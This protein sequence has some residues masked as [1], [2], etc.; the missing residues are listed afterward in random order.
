LR[1]LGVE[2]DSVVALCL[3]RGTDMVVASLAVWQAGAAYLPLDPEYPAE[4]LRYMVTDSRARVLVGHRAVAGR[5]DAPAVVWLD[6]DETAAEAQPPVRVRQ[7]QL[8]YVVYTSGS[9]GRPKGVQVRHGGVLNLVIGQEPVFGTGHEPV[10]WFA[11]FGFDGAV[12]EM[13]VP[14]AAGR[15]VVV[16]TAPERAEPHRLARLVRARAIGP[17]TLPPSL[18]K[19]FQPG[20]LDG[21]GTLA[22]GGERLEPGLAAAWRARHRMVNLY[23]P[24]ETTVCATVAEVDPQADG[25]PPIGAPVT[26]ARAYVVDQRLEPAPVGVPGELLVGGAGVARGYAGRPALTAERFVADPFAGDGSRAYRTGDRARWLPDGQLEFLGRADDQVKVRGFRIEPG[27]VEAVLA[28]HPAVRD[29]VVTAFGPD[30]DR[31]LAA[32]LVPAGPGEGLPPVADLRAFAGDRLPAFMVPAVFVELAALPVTATGKL[33]RAALPEPEPGRTGLDRW[34]EPAGPAEELIAGIWSQVLGVDRVGALDDFLELGG[35]SLLATQV[36][37]RM[38]A[39]F[40]VEIPLAAVFDRPTVRALAAL[41]GEEGD[42]GAPPIVP[43]HRNG[44]LPL[45]FAQQRLWFLDQLDPA[46]LEYVVPVRLRFGGELDFAALGGAL[47]VL[48]ARHEVLRTRLVATDGEAGQVIDLPAPVPLPVVDVSDAIDPWAVAQAVLTAGR[49]APFDL[50]AGP[51]LRACLIR[52]RTGDHI[53][54]LTLHHIVFDEWSARILRRELTALYE[55]LRA[56]EPDPLPPLPVQYRDFAIWQ[57]SWLSGPV[58]ERQLAYWREQ[59]SGPPAPEL[60]TDRPRPAMRSTRGAVAGFTVPAT[61]AD[62]LRVLSRRSGSTM[63]MTLYAALAV[64][65]GRYTGE[66]SVRIGTPVANRNRAE[67][68]G[69]IGFFVNT[70]VL[71]ADLSGDPAFTEVLR[72]VRRTALAAYAHQDLPFEQLVDEL[73]TE[74]DRSRTPLFQ[75][76]FNYAAARPDA[77]A[78]SD[79]LA[80]PAAAEITVKFDLAVVVSDG[81]DGLTGRLEYSTALFDSATAE[82]M[83]EHLTTLLTAVA[84]DAGRHLSELPMLTAAERDRVARQWQGEAAPAPAARSVAELIGNAAQAAPDAPAVVS[85]SAALTY[86]GLMRRANRLAHRLRR[87]GVGPESVVAMCLDRGLD[88]VVAMLAV[89]Q[90]GGAFLPLD[91]EYPAERLTYLLADSGTTVLVGHRSVAGDLTGGSTIWLDDPVTRAA[92]GTEPVTAPGGTAAAGQLAYVIYTSGSTGRPKGVQVAQ[93][94]AVNMAVALRATLGAAPGR[95]VLQFASF[96]FDASVL[97]VA[98]TLAAGG[99]LVV[100]G[101]AQRADPAALTSLVRRTG[102]QATSVTPSLLSA[103]DP[104]RLAGLSTLVL[105]GEP[106]TAP[107]AAA[108]RPGRRLVNTYGP[109]ETT[110]MVTTGAV[111]ADGHRAPPIGRPVPGARTYVLDAALRP[112]PVGVIG[113]LFIGGRPVARGY[114]HRPALT[115]ERFLADPFAADGSRMYRTGDRVR[116]LPDG[117]LDFAGRADQQIKLRGFRIEPAEVEAVLTGHAAVREAVVTPFGDAEDRRLVAYLVP[118]R[119]ADGIPSA[120]ELREHLRRSLPEFMVPAVF[121]E[122][123]AIPLT[124]NGKTDLTALPTPDAAR[125]GQPGEFVAPDGEAEETLAGIWSQVLGLERVG[126]EDNFFELGGHSLLATKVI[127]RIRTV[128]GIDLAVAALFDHPTVRTLASVVEARILDEIDGL[129]DD[130][131]LASLDLLSPAFPQRVAADGK[132]DENG[133]TR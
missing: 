57:R 10:L 130:E 4:R 86:A 125:T 101:A 21:V 51:L 112:V 24:T 85:G 50:A 114:G 40:G 42:T 44:P 48:V 41:V 132:P 102:A 84:A 14:L 27:E 68:E 94:S 80:A 113:E 97:D 63:F 70:L 47:N 98:V 16:A 53:L 71:P 61:V 79:P 93:D 76:L 116:W 46:S 33:D 128:L 110:V 62:R 103:L 95:R 8:A 100:A 91:P 55:A 73:V 38:R 13:W 106:L 83:A 34:E 3:E 60:P 115:A 133:V 22:T 82:R 9:T 99:T 109:T 15:T 111:D 28:A 49:G 5:L 104:A 2:P 75:V 105:G 43:M 90:A 6:E 77:A 12:P 121:T 127:S 123:S 65:L 18:L 64:L 59:L 131:V 39:V 37:S 107:V 30:G 74:R 54:A 52:V 124:P 26:N 7:D 69:L 96:S 108:W 117:R 87:A 89:W 66:S 32:Y 17:V 122:L 118:A 92:L 36:V 67:T 45:S 56:G 11:S 23:G 58:L 129:S 88:T 78:A 31:R 1:R 25:A 19:L 119:P 72:R 120:A 35:H 20:M 126:A 81:P 29:A